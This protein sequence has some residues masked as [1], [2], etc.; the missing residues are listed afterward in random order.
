[1]N[2]K[3]RLESKRADPKGRP[4][5]LLWPPQLNGFNPHTQKDV[6]DA[7]SFR[8]DRRDRLDG[9]YSLLL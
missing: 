9:M 1:M 5:I 2:K 6:T 4:W 7:T 3:S 8:T